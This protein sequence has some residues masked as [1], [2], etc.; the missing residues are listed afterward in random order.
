MNAPTEAKAAAIIAELITAL[1]VLRQE[2]ATERQLRVTAEFQL[3][4]YKHPIPPAIRAKM[5]TDRKAAQTA[6]DAKKAKSTT[7]Y[8]TGTE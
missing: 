7:T 5:E 2:L 8:P 3:L 4:A 1:A 6:H